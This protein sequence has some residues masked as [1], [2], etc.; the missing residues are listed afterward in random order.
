MHHRLKKHPHSV[1]AVVVM[2]EVV[3]NAMEVV[4]VMTVMMKVIAD[5]AFT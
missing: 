3:V 4:I 2:M 1:V 5:T